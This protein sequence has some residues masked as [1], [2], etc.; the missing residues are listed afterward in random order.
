MENDSTVPVG[1]EEDYRTAVN[2]R[3]NIDRPGVWRDSMKSVAGYI[4][5]IGRAER[6]IQILV[7]Q[8][9]KMEDA[10]RNCYR[11]LEDFWPELC[12]EESNQFHAVNLV[13]AEISEA[14]KKDSTA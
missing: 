7:D 2:E 4:E 13:K 3:D 12:G 10:L 8:N 14:L 11:L 5:R 9:A 1:L 6:E